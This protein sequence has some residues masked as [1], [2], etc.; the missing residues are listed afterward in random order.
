MPPRPPKRRLN[1][2]VCAAIAG[3]VLLLICISISVRL[4]SCRL[5][6]RARSKQ[7]DEA[8][9]NE[10]RKGTGPRQFRY[11]EL[12]TATDNFSDKKKLGEGGFG[13]VYR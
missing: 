13:S 11:S 7:D 2:S 10:L 12:A 1:L 5:E 9:E 4:F 8:M 6:R 3:S